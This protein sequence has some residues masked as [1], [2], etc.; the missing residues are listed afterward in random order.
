MSSNKC[1]AFLSL[2][3]NMGNR[4]KMLLNACRLLELECGSLALISPVYKT[5]PWGYD[6][7]NWYL[8]Q[9]VA[10]NT[11]LS[12]EE[13]LIETQKIELE[14]GRTT[15]TQTLYQDRPIDIDILVMGDSIVNTDRLAIP[16]KE[17]ANRKFVLK[18]LN[19]IMPELIIPV[20]NKSVTELLEETPDSSVLEEIRLETGD[21]LPLI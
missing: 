11:V 9:V 7:D 10:I 15:K 21:D 18:P 13:L 16:H 17:L 14:L 6:S 19:D 12:P 1:R 2:G 20:L 5:A 4:N 8:N 3:S